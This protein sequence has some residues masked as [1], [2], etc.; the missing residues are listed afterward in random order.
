MQSNRI[1][2]IR[3]KAKAERAEVS[4]LEHSLSDAELK[5]L[6][7][8]AT[9]WLDDVESFPAPTRAESAACSRTSLDQP[10][11]SDF[12]DGDPAAEIRPPTC[13]DPSP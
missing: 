13:R 10:R 2:E 6:L 4:R 5:E 8:T 3:S 9:S 11:G 12:A 7:Q 1:Q